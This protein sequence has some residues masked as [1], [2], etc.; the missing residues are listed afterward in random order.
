MGKIT[1]SR[2]AAGGHIHVSR[3]S[4]DGR[5]ALS[6]MNPLRF[7]STRE[8]VGVAAG[9]VIMNS[10]GG[11]AIHLSFR[12]V[13]MTSFPPAVFPAVNPPKPYFPPLLHFQDYCRVRLL[14]PVNVTIPSR[15]R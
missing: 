8:R 5:S 6:S 13:A 10:P 14:A 12:K 3:E 7:V 2:Y 11:N 4:L 9:Q 15:D 1:P